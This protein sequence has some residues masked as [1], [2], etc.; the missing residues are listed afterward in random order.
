MRP[1]F[2]E[3]VGK[4]L[5]MRIGLN[6]GMAVVGNMGSTRRFDYT[7]LGDAVNLA[8]RLE[9]VNKEFATYTLVSAMTRAQLGDEFP[10]REIGRVAVV[11]R[12]EPVQIFEP[13]S[14]SRQEQDA[15][16]LGQFDTAL[17]YYYRG[18][19]AVAAEQFAALAPHDPTARL[20][21]ARCNHLAER[22]PAEWDGVWQMQS[23]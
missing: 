6:T 20:Y 11:G 19:F 22:P 15:A 4:E 1:A 21:A 7:M 2:K 17:Q 10:L 9:G 18:D 23:K 13:L 3:R 14:R 5:H 12:R 16:Q 8:A